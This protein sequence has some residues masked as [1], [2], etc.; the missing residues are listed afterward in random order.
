MSNKLFP[1]SLL[2]LHSRIHY[3]AIELHKVVLSV[4]TLRSDDGDGGANVQKIGFDYQDN[5]SYL[6][7]RLRG[8]NGCAARTMEPECLLPSK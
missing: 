2:N 5:N 4:G 7:S 6:Y 8:A 3:T 1:N